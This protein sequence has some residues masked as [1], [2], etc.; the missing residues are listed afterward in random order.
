MIFVVVVLCNSKAG[1][2]IK[3]HWILEEISCM[4]DMY[5]TQTKVTH[6]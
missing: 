5:N 4:R 2:R 1:Q 3:V 6:S